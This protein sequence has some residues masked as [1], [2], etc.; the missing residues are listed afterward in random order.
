MATISSP[1]KE[2]IEQSP[3]QDFSVIITLKGDAL[4]PVLESKGKF[5]MGKQLFS[6]TLNG[7]EIQSLESNAQIEAI[8]ADMEM[9]IV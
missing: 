5:I 8:E 6:A 3:Q 4:P 7:K 1:L 2:Q 9:G